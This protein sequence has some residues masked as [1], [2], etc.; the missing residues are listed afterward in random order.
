MKGLVAG[1]YIVQNKL[2]SGSFGTIYSGQ[3]SKTR[4]RVAIK[5][6]L[7]KTPCAQLREEAM[8]YSY[9]SGSV[10]IAP[11]YSFTSEQDSFAMVM[12]L[13]GHSVE[14]LFEMCNHKLS[15]K[16]V[17]MLADQMI[18]SLEFMHKM[19]YIHRDVKPA[20][21][22]IGIGNN[23]NKLF[24][25]DLGL[26]KLYR[27][28]NTHQHF[29]F[30]ENNDLTGTA[31]FASLTAMHG[32]EQSRR[33]DME[34]LAY[35]WLYLLSGSLPWMSVQA[36]DTKSQCKKICEIKTKMK[37]TELFNGFPIE[38]S[39]YLA[40]IRKLR[41][42]DEPNYTK[43]KKMFR[44]L[45]I[46]SGFTYDYKYDWIDKTTYIVR[47]NSGNQATFLKVQRSKTQIKLESRSKSNIFTLQSSQKSRTPR[48]II[49]K[50][51]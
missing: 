36:T 27:N 7:L 35:V 15:L 30:T 25:I 26:A 28:P 32:N 41:F 40:E 50:Q 29:N 11:V 47:Q 5:F 46:K 48:K 19:N 3:D 1:R 16:T 37:P 45:F 6:E 2:G 17:L 31:K 49:Q 43:Y 34:S 42:S 51:K 13:L 23:R 14:Q 33:D 21:F 22:A 10:N 24:L 39:N 18:T 8:L 4:R 20:N 44:D 12:E 38:F 9:L